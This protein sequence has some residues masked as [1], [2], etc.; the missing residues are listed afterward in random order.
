MKLQT[1][2]TIAGQEGVYVVTNKDG[3]IH[4]FENERGDKLHFV[5]KAMKHPKIRNVTDR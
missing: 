5:V 2:V 4:T 3:N 1:R